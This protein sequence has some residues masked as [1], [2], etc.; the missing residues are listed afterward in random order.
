METSCARIMFPSPLLINPGSI[1]S[2]VL[3]SHED[4]GATY[5]VGLPLRDSKCAFFGEK[6]HGRRFKIA[7]A[8]QDQSRPRLVSP[9][10]PFA[11]S[12]RPIT[13][14]TNQDAG[15]RVIRSQ[16]TS[17]LALC[18]WAVRPGG[19]LNSYVIGLQGRLARI[20][21]HRCTDPRHLTR[22]SWS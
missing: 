9:A 14:G 8:S 1:A 12:G 16:G 18:C 20:H 2:V 22:T 10:G 21:I 15:L 7:A 4:T 3:L 6:T 19:P 11:R 17:D 5:Q 13:L